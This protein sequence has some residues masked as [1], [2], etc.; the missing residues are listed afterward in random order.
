MGTD[1]KSDTE[2]T[3]YGEKNNNWIRNYQNCVWHRHYERNFLWNPRLSPTERHVS[4]EPSLITTDK[5][6]TRKSEHSWNPTFPLDRI[7]VLL[8]CYYYYTF[9][10][11]FVKGLRSTEPVWGKFA[12]RNHNGR[13][14]V[15]FVTIMSQAVFRSQF[16]MLFSVLNVSRVSPLL[17]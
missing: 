7:K 14:V 5:K 6:Q 11:F 8:I 16:F 15:I 1:N 4:T 12:I 13:T 9:M 2:C 3:I 10:L 17:H